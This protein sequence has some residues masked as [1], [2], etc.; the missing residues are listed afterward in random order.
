MHTDTDGCV[1]AHP[2][3]QTD[4]YTHIDRHTHRQTDRQMCVHTLFLSVH[5]YSSLPDEVHSVHEVASN[6]PA[7]SIFLLSIQYITVENTRLVCNK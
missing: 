2:H 5:S 1:R 4:T 7:Q 6:V 3:A